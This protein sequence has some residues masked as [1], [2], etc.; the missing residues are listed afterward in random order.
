[1]TLFIATF[2]IF[3]V[4]M[5][6]LAVGVLLGRRAIK[7]SCGGLASLDGAPA[8]PCSGTCENSR[9]AASERAGCGARA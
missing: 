5:L 3:G 7:G 2:V 9:S 8:C 1:M 6:A 4:A